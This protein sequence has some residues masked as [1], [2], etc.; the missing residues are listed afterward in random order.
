MQ[1]YF[2]KGDTYPGSG[3]SRALARGG[4]NTLARRRYTAQMTSLLPP[5]HGLQ[6]RGAGAGSRIWGAAERLLGYA[7]LSF[8]ASG[9]QEQ[10]LCP[11]AVHSPLGPG[12]VEGTEEGP[13]SRPPARPRSQIKTTAQDRRRTCPETPKGSPLQSSSAKRVVVACDR[14]TFGARSMEKLSPIVPEK[15]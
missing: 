13:T 14:A 5:R 9:D 6:E 7:S 8:S 10:F 2:R 4:S 11:G 15:L 1:Q 3:D 12:S